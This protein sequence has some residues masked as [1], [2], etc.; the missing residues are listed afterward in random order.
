MCIRM[1]IYTY[2]YMYID[3]S[4]YKDLLHLSMLRDVNHLHHREDMHLIHWG[5]SQILPQLFKLSMSIWF[6]DD[7][8]NSS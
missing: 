7:L 2:M 1:Y 5:S 3:H 6:F 4:K 8:G